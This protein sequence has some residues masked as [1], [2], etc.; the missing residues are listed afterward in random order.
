M[1]P[2][3][4]L[5]LVWVRLSA[6]GSQVNP[7]TTH[8]PPSPTDSGSIEHITEPV[9]RDLE[10]VEALLLER[11]DSIAPMIRQVGGYTFDG[12]GKR[13]RPLLA[14]LSASMCGYRGP[15]II[16]VAAAG[17]FLHTASLVHDDVVDG[18]EARRGRDSVNQRFGSRVAVLVGD[19]MLA[20]CSELLVEDGSLE[21]LG[22]YA[23]SI[24][25][26]AE[27][28][29]LQLT[30]SFDPS[31]S[32]TLYLQ[33][34]GCKTATL[35]ATAAESGAIL[36]DVSRA[37]VRA[38]REFGWQLGIAFQL[39]D[40]AL[41][42]ASSSAELGKA[43][44]ADVREGKVTLPLLYALSRCSVGER[45]SIGSQLKEFSLQRLAD[46]E[47]DGDALERVVSAV[48]RHKGVE[49]TLERAAECTRQARKQIE[50]FPG[51]DSKAA[52]A[53]LCDFV[54]RRRH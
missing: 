4:A 40:D 50:S 6:V 34:I 23:E 46:T 38:V 14:L 30:N 28:E 37:Q 31:M 20:T 47:P 48:E 22:S 11:T 35:I 49:L 10:R 42:Y 24:R 36:A 53:A 3:A 21:V 39:V 12:G 2:T 18:A 13:I 52:L 45:D 54:V 8:N 32:E 51:S 16:K 15:R 25:K 1:S 27:G 19:F 7:P 33:I 44:L 41:D 9:Q 17:E 5:C 29:V 26:M 43:R